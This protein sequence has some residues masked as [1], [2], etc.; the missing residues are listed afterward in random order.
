MFIVQHKQKIPKGGI[1]LPSIFLIVSFLVNLVNRM[2]ST[3]CGG[4]KDVYTYLPVLLIFFF[5]PNVECQPVGQARRGNS[6]LWD[7]GYNIS[8]NLLIGS[9][10]V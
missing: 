8:D 2:S 4:R 7:L 9:P 10:S 6:Q 5:P 1:N 3:C